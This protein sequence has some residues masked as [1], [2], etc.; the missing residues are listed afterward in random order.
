MSPVRVDRRAAFFLIV[1]ACGAYANLFAGTFQF[2]D[3]NVILREASAQSVSAWWASQPGIRPLLK[4]TYA[5]NNTVLAHDRDTGLALFHVV[6]LLLHLG[7]ALLVYFVLVR[8]THDNDIVFRDQRLAAFLAA[9]V[10]ALHPAQ[11]EAVTYVSG[12]STALAALF[13]LLSLLL[14]LRGVERGDRADLHLRSPLAFA[15]ALLCKEYV[16][17]LP[18]ALVLAARLQT[19]RPRWIRWSLRAS[20]VHWLVAAAALAAAA[21]VPRYRELLAASLDA[22]GIAENLWLQ[23][24]A[25]GWLAGQLVRPDRLNADPALATT[26]TF[27]AASIATVAAVLLVLA[28]GLVA[29]RLRPVL[30]FSVLWFFAWLLPTN[31]VLPRLD[32]VNDRQLYVALIGPAFGAARL[33]LR[34]TPRIVHWPLVPLIALGLAWM[35]HERNT[36][37]EN[38]VVF[39]ADVARKSPANARAFANLG[40]ALAL[41]CRRAEA[42]EALTIALRLDPALV[43]PAINLQRLREGDPAAAC[44]PATATLH[45]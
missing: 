1:L 27:D 32:L 35:T 2:D 30:A 11:T 10:F 36:V 21:A 5:L 3:Y 13:G 17:V 42:E 6:N 33:L 44:P 8:L 14:W 20:I 40:Y 26:V 16:V 18:L 41:E 39:W 43:Q 12:R 34:F 19:F 28:A 38:E 24:Q 15:V 25:I 45:R 4:L 22:R 37:Y 29:L 7:N 31:S 9:A 23:A